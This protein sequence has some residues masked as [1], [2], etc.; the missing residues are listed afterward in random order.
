M[1]RRAASPKMD[2]G[3]AARQGRAVSLAIAAF[4]NGGDAIAF[5]NTHHDGLGAR[6]IDLAVASADGLVSVEQ[7]IATARR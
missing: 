6:P 5:L 2:A 7:A 1:F 3:A 4:G